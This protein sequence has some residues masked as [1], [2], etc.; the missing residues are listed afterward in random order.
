MVTSGVNSPKSAS[1]NI[2]AVG[3]KSVWDVRVDR[4]LFAIDYPY[5]QD[6]EALHF[7]NE[8]PLTAADKEKMLHGNA[9][10]LFKVKV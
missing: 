7:I 10:K 3:R 8:A 9:E 6:Q 2:P 1:V 5:E 4:I